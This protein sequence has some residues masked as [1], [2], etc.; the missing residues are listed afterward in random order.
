MSKNTRA[1]VPTYTHAYLPRWRDDEGLPRLS[2]PLLAPKHGKAGPPPP[3]SLPIKYPLPTNKIC[4]WNRLKLSFYVVIITLSRHYDLGC[5][6][7]MD[8]ARGNIQILLN[9]LYF[10]ETVEI[11]AY[12]E[13]TG[14]TKY[15]FQLTPET[16]QRLCSKS[17]KFPA[18][19]RLFDALRA[20]GLSVPLWC[21][22]RD[23]YIDGR[24][25]GQPQFKLPLPGQY[26]RD[27]KEYADAFYSEEEMEFGKR[28]M[29]R[30][31][32][33]YAHWMMYSVAA[34]ER[35]SREQSAAAARKAREQEKRP[36]QDEPP[37]LDT[38]DVDFSKFI[39]ARY[40]KDGKDHGTKSE[41]KGN[42]SGG[43]VRV[44]Q[45][46]LNFNVNPTSTS[47]VQPDVNA[48]A[49]TPNPGSS[50][51]TRP[52]TTVGPPNAAGPS[53]RPPTAQ[54]GD[55]HPA[56][57][58]STTASQ[59]TNPPVEGNHNTLVEGRLNSLTTG[60]DNN[61]VGGSDNAL[62]QGAIDSLVQGEV[63]PS[64]AQS[65]NFIFNRTFNMPASQQTDFY[66]SSSTQDMIDLSVQD[67]N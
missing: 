29:L 17:H 60:T 65:L 18:Y 61:L 38:P 10:E 50:N 42:A 54:Q 16:I 45:Q 32:A 3:P 28:D 34:S 43:E 62:A 67:L 8:Q 21:V 58:I 47:S 48:T 64:T 6:N 14:D 19:N 26:D 66:T 13:E 1:N 55:N 36:A 9:E 49:T 59:S 27:A 63:T 20:L 22:L 4:I 5:N 33:N 12:I 37:K 52:S 41:K 51:A 24:V 11:A 40:L 25:P 56:Q 57:Q 46:T 44:V 15:D 7:P 53:G 23:V 35:R 39:K 30:E 31:L 2:D